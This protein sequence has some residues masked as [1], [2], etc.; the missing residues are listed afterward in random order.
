M[1][2]S[3]RSRFAWRR[4]F[5]LCRKEALQIVRDPSS[6]LIAFVLPAVLLFIFGYG[7]NLDSSNTRLGVVVEDNGPAARDFAAALIAA[8]AFTIREM[9]SIKA[10]EEAM[11]DGKI[12]GYVAIANDFGSRL[13]RGE[14]PPVFV[15]T[16][17]AEP[18]SASLVAGNVQGVWRLWQQQ[19]HADRG[20]HAAPPISIE[21]RSWYNPSAESR[22]FLIPGSIVI[23]M[24]IL[25]ALLTALVVAREW[26][27]GTMEAL[28]AA[29]ITRAELLLS[30]LIPYYVLGILAMVTCMAVAVLI[31]GVPFRGSLLVLLLV[32][33]LFL[34]GTLG[35]GLLIST[36][37]R[38]QFNAAQSALNLGYMPAVMLSG[39]VYEI[40]SMPKFAQAFSY[41]LPA[42]YFMSSLQSLF[43]AGVIWSTLWV[44]MLFMSLLALIFIGL[45]LLKTKE[46]LE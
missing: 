38:N 7:V 31:M 15:A 42:R 19:W 44:D 43:Q 34:G 5:A 2:S 12:R 27:R 29:Q 26:E 20:V 28:L 24:T 16:D 35:L 22:N 36:V 10:A 9:G 45:T 33:T 14:A 25:G 39:F 3:N 30:K 21:V 23:I 41:A 8:D 11:L 4:V 32:S 46:M 1:K 37:T 40:A 18:N 6:I 17:A 13:T